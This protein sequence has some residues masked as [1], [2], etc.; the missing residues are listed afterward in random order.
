MYGSFQEALYKKGDVLQS[1]LRCLPK[2]HLHVHTTQRGWNSPCSWQSLG[3]GRDAP[4]GRVG[5][6]QLVA[7]ASGSAASGWGAETRSRRM[8][9]ECIAMITHN[10][11]SKVNQKMGLYGAPPLQPK[12]FGICS[13]SAR[14]ILDAA[15]IYNK[16]G[17]R[18]CFNCCS[19]AN[20]QAGVGLGCHSH[21]I[22]LSSSSKA[23]W[24]AAAAELL[25]K[26]W[27]KAL[28]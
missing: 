15:A 17:L 19:N 8:H 16:T 27:S 23:G 10:K 22:L 9:P 14:R 26:G 1:V 3:Q 6:V 2:G 4:A 18:W 7:G 21:L 11:L 12:L 20:S 28:Q 5:F 25:C 13:G 24:K